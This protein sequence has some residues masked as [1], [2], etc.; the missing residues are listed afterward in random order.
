MSKLTFANLQKLCLEKL[1][2]KEADHEERG[3]GKIY[4]KEKINHDEVISFRKM[5]WF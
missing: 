3:V 2:K 4:A 5:R 1:Y